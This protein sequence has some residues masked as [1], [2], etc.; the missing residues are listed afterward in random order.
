MR[1]RFRAQCHCPWPCCC[2]R[3]WPT[4]I[5]PLTVWPRQ[6]WWFIGVALVSLPASHWCHCQRQAVLVAGVAPVLLLS[7]PSKVRPVQ[8]WRLLAL[9]WCFICIELASLPALCCCHCCRHCAGIVA[10]GAWASLPSSR[11]PRGGV[12][13]STVIA[14]RCIFAISGVVY[15]PHLFSVA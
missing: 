14:V 8:R 3:H 7:W 11:A 4:A 13:P 9:R 15:A 1:H 10:L 6:R 12:C 2:T 5:W